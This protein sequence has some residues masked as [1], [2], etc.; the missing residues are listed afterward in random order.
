MKNMENKKELTTG[1]LGL[2]LLDRFHDKGISVDNIKLNK[3]LFLLDLSF[4]L[5]YG[6]YLSNF[7]YDYSRHGP[8]S[9]DLKSNLDPHVS[10]DIQRHEYYEYLSLNEDLKIITKKI[11]IKDII[12]ENKENIEFIDAFVDKVKNIKGWSLVKYIK[13]DIFSDID[14]DLDNNGI[15]KLEKK[16][17]D[18]IIELNRGK[19]E[20]CLKSMS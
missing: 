15:R 19:I 16:E 20:K 14:L 11:S 13:E 5:K 18:K 6:E 2:V 1:M 12:E 7:E 17:M 8:I 10:R 3:S 4:K 9:L